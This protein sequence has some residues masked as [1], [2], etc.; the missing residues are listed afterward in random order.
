MMNTCCALTSNDVAVLLRCRT[1]RRKVDWLSRTASLH[2]QVVHGAV[3]LRRASC[4]VAPGLWR[5][6][7]FASVISCI[8]HKSL[9]RTDS[10]SARVVCVDFCT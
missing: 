8:Y 7:A 2:C 9:G 10:L 3:T 1:G 6:R 5:D 4:C